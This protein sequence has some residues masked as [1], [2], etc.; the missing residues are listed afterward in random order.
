MGAMEKVLVVGGSGFLGSALASALK[1]RGHAVRVLDLNPHPD[2]EIESQVGDICDPT[3]VQKACNGMDTVFQTAA[4]VDWGPRS[5]ERLFAVNVQGNRNVLEASRNA[6]VKRFIYT[7]SIDTVFDGS[8]IS[9]GDESLPYPAKHL[10]DYGHTK[11]LAEQ[12]VLAANGLDEMS[13][14]ALRVA[15]IYGPGDKM[16][17]L[18]ILDRA[19]KGFYARMGDGKAKFRHVYISNAVHAHILA[20]NAL[21]GHSK[22]AGQAYFIGD[23]EIINFFE[24]FV[25][26]LHAYNLSPSKIRLPFW[27]MY[28]LAVI[29]EELARLGIGPQKPDLTRY[30]ILSTCRDFYFSN[31]KA[32]RDFDY[33]P[34]VSY[35]KGVQE[36][37]TWLK[38]YYKE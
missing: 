2:P 7:S 37:I 18:I 13:T 22:L 32:R 21:D 9:N 12:E 34:L 19:K 36:T 4:L 29:S 24:F 6:G 28:P 3:A 16:R 10:D 35:E 5:R 15:G 1:A 20:G 38:S 8:A 25:P 31:E 26:F 17:L 11:A 14:C 33:E 23:N 27:L 30:V